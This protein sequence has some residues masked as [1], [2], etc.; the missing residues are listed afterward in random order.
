MNNI[1]EIKTEVRKIKLSDIV[2]KDDIYARIEKDQALISKYAEN[3]NAILNSNNRILISQGGILMD[4]WHR[5]KA[6]ERVCG[7]EFELDVD[8]FLTDNTD[9]I[10]IESYAANQK[11][12]KANSKKDTFR[13]IQRLY[14]KGHDR[15]TIQNKLSVSKSWVN[16]ATKQQRAT[17]KE[18]MKRVAVEMYLR[19]GSTYKSIADELDIESHT[20]I[21]D[22]VKNVEM[23]TNGQIDKEW[24]LPSK[25]ANHDATKP[26]RYNIWNL[27]KQD[28]KNGAHFGSFPQRFMENLLYYYTEPLD[29]VFDPFAG[30]GTT[31][32][33]CK[34]MFRRYYCTDIQVIPGRENDI[35]HHDI[36][37]GL[38]DN[39]P[40]SNLVFLDPPY[41][42]QA[43]G[44]YTDIESDLSNIPLEDFY[45]VF[46]TLFKVVK[47]KMVNGGVL[48]FI[49]QN[50]QWKND[51]KHVEPHSH[52]MW[53][54][55][56]A[57]GFKFEHLI[58]VPYSTQQYNAQMVEYA[59]TYK[60]IL[61]L[62]RE[63]VVLRKP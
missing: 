50:T 54:I 3:A 30:G 27:S 32:D 1:K 22:I 41:W 26:F 62:N 61:Q 37:T 46:R 55:A 60:I 28:N 51:D 23:T 16:E 47:P 7:K 36:T 35:I 31:V 25:D 40:K 11:H 4:G 17:E 2:F 53:N 52:I 19:A 13:N 48:A 21:R 45:N 43:Q 15:D 29:I 57:A 9:A 18:E 24:N 14:A 12:G 63:L 49:I 33:A 44:D 34:A 6:F 38:P 58:Q 39:L 20:T 8:V 10:E 42:K 5:W 56:E 59:K